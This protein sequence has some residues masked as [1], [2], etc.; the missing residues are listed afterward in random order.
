M[1]SLLWVPHTRPRGWSGV[2]HRAAPTDGLLGPQ[3]LGPRTKGRCLAEER[4][5]TRGYIP[6]PLSVRWSQRRPSRRWGRMG[7]AWPWSLV[8]KGMF[9]AEEGLVGRPEGLPVCIHTSREG[10]SVDSQVQLPG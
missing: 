9:Q 4:P 5:S 1:A 8:G 10:S 3:C 2:C 7:L 6:G